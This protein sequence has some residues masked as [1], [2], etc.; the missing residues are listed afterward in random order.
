MKI[1]SKHNKKDFYDYSGFG[2]DTSDDIIFLRF[3]E[4]KLSATRTTDVN[5]ST[6][7]ALLT[8]GSK[9]MS[10]FTISSASILIAT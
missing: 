7:N 10:L 2:Y 5:T 8:T 3:P 1:I 6:T 9:I 4:K